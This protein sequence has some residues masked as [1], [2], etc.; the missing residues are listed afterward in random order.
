MKMQTSLTNPLRIDAVPI[1]GRGGAVGMTFC[2][3]KKCPGTS[4][5][6][7][8]DLSLDL[9]AIRDWGAEILVSLIEKHEYDQVGIADFEQ[10]LPEGMLHLRLP[11][12]DAS[13]PGRTW[14]QRW[15]REGNLVRS[16]LRRGGR[17]CLHCM[18]G[19]GRTGMIAARLLVEFGVHP[20]D[21][22][23]M[24]R[25]ARPGA[26][27]TRAQEDYVRSFEG[28]WQLRDRFR[29]CLLGGACGDALG[30]PVEFK[31]LAVIRS[32]FGAGGIRD[33]APGDYGAGSI[34]DDTQMTLFT[35]EGLIR[36]AIER[37]TGRGLRFVQCLHHAYLRWLYTQESAVPVD[38]SHQG[39]LFT[40][41]ELFSRRAPGGTC[42]SALRAAEGIGTPA[43]AR[44]TSKGC[45]TVMRAAPPALYAL[46]TEPDAARA[47]ARAFSLAVIS[48]QL[49]HGHPTGYLAAGAF[50][51]ILCELAGEVP[52]AAAVEHTIVRLR[53]ETGGEET[54]Q[55]LETALQLAARHTD[56]E[57]CIATLGGGWVAEEALAIAVFCA[58]RADS[59]EEG[60]IMAVNIEGDSDST[61]AM[62]G[63][64]LGM[65]HGT[66]AIPPRWLHSLELQDTIQTVADDLFDLHELGGAPWE[67]AHPDTSPS[68]GME[69]NL[70]R[71]LL[72]RERAW[73]EE[74][75]PGWE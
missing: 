40:R 42:L 20:E 8:R 61:G 5:Y 3:G 13:V 66:A 72:Q 58:L 32:L 10:H 49:T 69:H 71:L 38:I 37:C 27:E 52:L 39:L 15:K 63:N 41:R 57:T 18:G 23:R 35:A 62:T 59:L 33:F 11:I 30:A 64:L 53:Q 7:D 45:G 47:G 28:L 4:G 14:E 24:V 70:R 48:G 21:A 16:V 17:V 75:W 9:R 60:I 29:G 55:K 65:L 43:I 54:I 36:A 67:A 26:I 51:Q 50:A 1:H 22:I 73:W 34:T 74:R 2:P 31:P 56:S 12:E 68:A 6:H 44:N 25:A 46:A 19:L